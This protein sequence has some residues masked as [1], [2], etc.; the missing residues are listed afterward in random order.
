MGQ[1]LRAPRGINLVAQ[2]NRRIIGFAL[3]VI[4]YGLGHTLTIDVDPAARRRGVA[5]ALMAELHR[6]FRAKGAVRAVLEV[7]VDNRPARRLFKKL[8][9]TEIDILRDYYGPGRDGIRAAR[10]L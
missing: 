8:G 3:G 1:L 10:K 9:Y 2:S 7:A 5:T 6:L 4:H